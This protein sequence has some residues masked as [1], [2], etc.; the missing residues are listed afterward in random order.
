MWRGLVEHVPTGERSYFNHFHALLNFMLS[1]LRRA[2]VRPGLCLRACLR[3]A[4]ALHHRHREPVARS[5][6]T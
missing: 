6:Q 2:G 4:G 5:S 3:L 1:H